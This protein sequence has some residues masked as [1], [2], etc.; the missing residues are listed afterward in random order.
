MPSARKLDTRE[1]ILDAAL[2]CF[3]ERGVVNTGIEDIRK[4]AGASPSSMYHQFDGLPAIV[5][6]LLE[7][8]LVRRYGSVTK[9]VVRVKKAR[10]AVETLVKAH[11]AWVMESPVEA[12]FMYRALA[13]DMDEG[14]REALVATK[15][16]L[17]AELTAHFTKLGVGV[18]GMPADSFIDVILLGTTHQACRRWLA[19]PGAVEAKWMKKWLPQLAWRT[20]GAARA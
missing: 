16:Q 6:A 1:A 15:M 20:V 11:L 4:A 2:R 13:L 5:A 7:R 3:D 17:K 9:K 14:H 12:R 18:H 10:E 19:A 8:T